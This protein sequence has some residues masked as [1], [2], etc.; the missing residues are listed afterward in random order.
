MSDQIPSEVWQQ[1]YTHL[2]A[3]GDDHWEDLKKA[4]YYMPQCR[5]TLLPLLLTCQSFQ[6]IAEPLLYEH[7]VVYLPPAGSPSWTIVEAL[8]VKEDR[9]LWVK[10]LVATWRPSG[11]DDRT[12]ETCCELSK[13]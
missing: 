1:I 11:R 6:A 7:V 8:Q 13:L 5:S 12:V 2:R 10:T 9:R 3:S 4:G